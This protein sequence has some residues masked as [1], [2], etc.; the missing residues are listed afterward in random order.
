MEL[1][2]V[3]FFMS[4]LGLTFLNWVKFRNVLSP[5]VLLCGTFSLSAFI[6]ALQSEWD[7]ELSV[8][9]VLFMVASVVLFSVGCYIGEFVTEGK[10]VSNPRINRMTTNDLDIQKNFR[11]LLNIVSVVITILYVKN[12]M[13]VAASLGS[14]TDLFST[15]AALRS[16]ILSDTELLQVGTALNFGIS[17]VRAYGYIALFLIVKDAVYKKHNIF[18]NIIPVI[19]LLVYILYSSSRSTLIT[20]GVSIIFS[21]YIVNRQ[22]N[23]LNINEMI[24]KKIIG[25]VLIFFTIFYYL[26]M[27]TGQSVIFN[28]KQTIAIY[29]SS[30]L[31]CFDSFFHSVPSPSLLPGENTFVGLYSFFRI[32]GL[33]DIPIQNH[34]ADMVHFGNAY[35]NIYTAFAPYI[36]DFGIPFALSL[37]FILGYLFQ[38]IWDRFNRFQGSLFLFINYGRFWALPLIYYPIAERLMTTNIAVNVMVEIFFSVIIIKYFMVGYEGKKVLAV[39]RSNLKYVGAMHE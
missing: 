9:T 26:G 12:R 4:M 13:S 1:V 10:Y 30:G 23:R 22:I 34:H 6:L 25:G 5:A 39:S 27:S 7:W 15:R 36:T 21:L 17:F 28:L 8:D 18:N 19:C 38:R 16:A 20:V 24:V 3:L 31:V 2:N 29:I 11:I 32:L 37:Q 14:V 33:V 35:S